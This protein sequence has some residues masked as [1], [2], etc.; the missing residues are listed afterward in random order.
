MPWEKVGGSGA[1][2]IRAKTGMFQN[3]REEH[4]LRR[5]GHLMVLNSQERDGG[6]RWI[7]TIEALGDCEKSRSVR[8]PWERKTDWE[9]LQ[10]EWENEVQIV[11]N[12]LN[13]FYS[14]GEL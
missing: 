1:R 3:P 4:V 9:V 13:T 2:G 7:G 8:G 5:T 11:D 12:P 14:E 10:S 6:V